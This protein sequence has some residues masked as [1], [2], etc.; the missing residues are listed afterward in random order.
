MSKQKKDWREELREVMESQPA[1]VPEFQREQ[2]DVARTEVEQFII[3]TVVPAYEELEAELRNYGR[4]VEIDKRKYQASIHVFKGGKEE[5][6][7]GI[8]GHVY[9]TMSFAFPEFGGKNEP[10]ITKA[11]IMPKHGGKREYELAKFTRDGIIRDF[12]EE[13]SDWAE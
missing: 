13:Y 7:Y 11:E 12:L 2:I 9:H 6:S 4:D 10:R 3:E 8:R 5:F 1:R